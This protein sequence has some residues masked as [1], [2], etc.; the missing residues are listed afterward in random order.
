MREFNLGSIEQK[1]IANDIVPTCPKCNATDKYSIVKNGKRGGIQRYKCKDCNIKF[2][3]FT[4]T[5]LEKTD[6][7][8]KFGLE[9]CK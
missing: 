3:L 4:D 9:L 7:I 1:M 5:I 8:G 6:T 2:S